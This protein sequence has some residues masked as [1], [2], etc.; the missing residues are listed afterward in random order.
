MVAMLCAAS[1]ACGGDR[2]SGAGDDS[3][4]TPEASPTPTAEPTPTQ[5]PGP[6]IAEVVDD[7]CTTS[8]VRPL[9]EQL[10]AELNCLAPG[11]VATMP[12]D[13]QLDVGNIF[14]FLQTAAGES[15]PAVLDDRPGATM[16][17][18]SA[19]RS[20]AQQ[21]LLYQ[22]YEDG[23]C[24]IALAAMPGSSNHERGLAIDIGDSAGWRDELEAHA[25]DWL[26]S[27]DPVHYDFEG[28][29]T[30]NIQGRSVLA[31]QRLWNVNHPDDEIDEDGLYGP[32]TG[33]KLALAPVNGFAIGSTCGSDPSAIV[34]FR[35]VLEERP[36][37]CG[38]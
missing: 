1:S 13:P 15:L 18:N 31:F 19:L 10:I 21:Y 8:V 33:G 17:V 36:E 9:S 34:A 28:A 25:W 38:L 3:T 11:A 20:L 24:G 14:D 4:P 35:W 23:R 5:P 6:T 32:Q 12:A 26:G 16:T 29:G 30:V 7:G 37:T 22:W 27:S 2:A